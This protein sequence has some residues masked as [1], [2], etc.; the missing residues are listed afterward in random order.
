M[1]ASGSSS[2]PHLAA[3]RAYKFN[4]RSRATGHN[5]LKADPFA[6]AAEHPPANR[7]YHH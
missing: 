1:A 7:L 4:V 3:G 2:C 5:Q 6:F